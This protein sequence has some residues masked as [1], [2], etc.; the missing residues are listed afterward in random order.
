ML[1]YQETWK[2]EKIWGT[3]LDKIIIL[4][5]KYNLPPNEMLPQSQLKQK[6]QS[7]KL[8]SISWCFYHDC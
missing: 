3:N 5:F 4:L 2:L 8:P 7:I 1:T 6:V